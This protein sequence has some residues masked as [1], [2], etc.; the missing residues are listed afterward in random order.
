M[1]FENHP[2]NTLFLFHRL[3]WDHKMESDESMY[4]VLH[5]KYQE[6]INASWALSAARKEFCN[7][8]TINVTIMCAKSLCF[9]LMIQFC[10]AI[11]RCFSSRHSRVCYYQAMLV[12]L[13]RIW[14]G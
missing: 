6:Y 13:R 2:E 3:P 14:N 11:S 4:N 12:R 7:K 5:Q 1:N 9:R 10:S 8:L